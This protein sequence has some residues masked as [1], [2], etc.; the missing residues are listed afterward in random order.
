[1]FPAADDRIV[2][3]GPGVALT[4]LPGE[5]HASFLA[6]EPPV[7]RSISRLADA[8]RPGRPLGLNGLP[9]QSTSAEL[10][11]DRQVIIDGLDQVLPGSQIALGGLDRSVAEQKLD[12]FEI[13][14]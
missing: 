5:C 7:N 2:Q 10:G 6:H 11:L 14:A 13:A 3:F 12:L 9:L 4:D 8:V 1:L